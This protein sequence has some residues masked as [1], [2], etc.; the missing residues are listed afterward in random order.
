MTMIIIISVVIVESTQRP[1]SD[2][3]SR[4]ESAWSEKLIILGPFWSFETTKMVM[5]FIFGVDDDD[6]DDS[7]A[8]L[9]Q[10]N[11]RNLDHLRGGIQEISLS[12]KSHI[13]PSTHTYILSLTHP[14]NPLTNVCFFKLFFYLESFWGSANKNRRKRSSLILELRLV[15]K[16]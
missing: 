5:R 10:L 7:D 16:L 8:G 1:T 15:N 14:F 6:D 3:E 4:S 2:K 13:H 9:G 11:L 12:M